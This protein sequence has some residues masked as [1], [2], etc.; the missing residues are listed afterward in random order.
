[1][2]SI[3]NNNL[4]SVSFNLILIWFI[5]TTLDLSAGPCVLL[6]LHWNHFDISI[7]VGLEA[8]NR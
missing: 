1:M 3:F 4:V 5:L 7:S 8:V 6:R 2:F